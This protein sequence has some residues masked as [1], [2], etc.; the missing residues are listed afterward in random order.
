MSDR[1]D[2]TARLAELGLLTAT[3]THELR[4]PLFALRSL[5][6][7]LGAKLDGEHAPLLAELL[8][9]ADL[10]GELVEGVGTYARRTEN[11]N[12]PVDT[13][14]VIDQAVALLRHRATRRA[15]TVEVERD[16]TLGAARG[17]RVALMQALVNVINNAIDACGSRVVV[18]NHRDGDQVVIEIEDDGPGIPAEIAERVFEPFF[19]TKEPGKGTGLGLAISR[20]LVQS[21]GGDLG[22]DTTGHGTLVRVVLPAWS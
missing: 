19:T 21:C 8:A 11:V 13:G 2:D 6:Q 17:D 14:A 5:V 7:L 15:A 1:L 10:L 3:L 9:Q 20:E 16:F 12:E 18:R 4:Q 22:L